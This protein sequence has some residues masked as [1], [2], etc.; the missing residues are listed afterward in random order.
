MGESNDRLLIIFPNIFEA[1]LWKL[2]MSSC[3]GMQQKFE[4]PFVNVA[5]RYYKLIIIFE[6]YL[7][8]YLKK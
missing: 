5:D 8:I 1:V 7:D 3:I 6:S 4:H 2:N